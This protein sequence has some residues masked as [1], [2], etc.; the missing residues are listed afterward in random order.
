MES[1]NKNVSGGKLTKTSA[2]RKFLLTILIFCAATLMCIV[3]PVVSSFVFKADSPLMVLS[4]A[5]WVSVM[6]LICAFYFGANVAQKHL[7]NK[8]T[9]QTNGENPSPS[10]PPPSNNP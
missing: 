10:D 1:E 6:S 9:P 8:T 7:L 3:P 4:G 5:E 2:G